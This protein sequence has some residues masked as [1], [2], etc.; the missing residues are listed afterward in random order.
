[1]SYDSLRDRMCKELHD[2]EERG[3]FC[4]CDLDDTHKLIASINGLDVLS[5]H[6]DA[7]R[8][9]DAVATPSSRSADWPTHLTLEEAKKWTAKMQNADG[10]TGSHWTPDQTSAVMSQKG[11]VFDKPDFYA[12]MN[13]MY[14]D[15]CGVAKTYGI[16]N[17]NFY[18]DL[19]AAF[20]HDKD[21]TPGK[22][23]KYLGVIVDG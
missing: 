21:A 6:S 18:A 4:R 15:Y 8:K 23:V 16:D 7:H 14:S 11:L 10:T 2:I 13:M 19:A 9:P 22:I 3:T 1:M 20:L 5:G 17:A 12:A